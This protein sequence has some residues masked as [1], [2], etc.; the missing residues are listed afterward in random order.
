MILQ[1]QRFKE[2]G[3]VPNVEQKLP[4]CHLNRLV[5]FQSIVQLAIEKEWIRDEVVVAVEAISKER[6]FKETGNAQNAE[7]K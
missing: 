7:L 3:N 1:G 5:I 6:D 2:T 4:S